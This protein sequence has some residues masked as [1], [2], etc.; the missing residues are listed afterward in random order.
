LNRSLQG[1]L[2]GGE[3]AAIAAME[4][5]EASKLPYMRT[6]AARVYG[7]ILARRGRLEEAVRQFERVFEIT[8]GTDASVVRLWAS[9][10]LIDALLALGRREE[11]KVR[12]AEFAALVARCETPRFE[13]EVERLRALV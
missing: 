11:A 13:A 7:V 12:L 5:A 6:E 4:R 2:E 10:D 9:P 3:A 8:E 1:D